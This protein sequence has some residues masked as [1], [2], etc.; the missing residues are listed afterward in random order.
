MQINLVKSRFKG[1]ALSKNLER[2]N[3][4]LMDGIIEDLLLESRAEQ[5]KIEISDKM[6]DDRVDSFLRRQPSRGEIYSNSQ[7]KSTVLKDL[8][9]QRV[10]AGEVDAHI[11]VDEKDILAACRGDQGNN[12][13]VDV[14]HILVRGDD[15]KALSTINEL[16]ARLQS[17][18]DFEQ[19]AME[20]SQDPSAKRN[21]GR[22][23]FISRGQFVKSFEDKAFS[24]PIGVISPPVRT[25]FGYHLIKVFQERSKE[26][27][28]CGKLSRVAKRGYQNRIYG[29][30]RQRRL[31]AFLKGIREKADIKV[32]E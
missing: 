32:I 14:G 2:V 26:S 21:R 3:Q 25:Q 17:G 10:L 15:A 18:A 5:L 12:R 19:L 7:L 16:Q 4:R 9:R 28:D 1:E 8:L 11:R 22:L 27:R 6:I 20:H 29:K 23:G 24:M 30:K 31:Q 13:E